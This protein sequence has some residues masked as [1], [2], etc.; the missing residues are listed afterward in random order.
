MIVES[1]FF[2]PIKSLPGIS[3]NEWWTEPKG[4]R[5]DRRMMLIDSTNKFV[6][7]RGVPEL[8]HCS[9]ELSEN[10]FLRVTHQSIGGDGIFLNLENP[11]IIDEIEVVI[12]NDTVKAGL[13][14]THLSNW[15]SEV[16]NKDLRLVFMEASQQR[17]IDLRYANEGEMVSFADGY[18]YLI[19]Q[20]SSLDYFN[21]KLDT[22]VEMIRFRPNIVLKGG[23]SFEEDHW[24]QLR[25]GEVEFKLVKPCGRC[26]VINID[27]NLLDLNPKVMETLKSFR[28]PTF[29]MNACLTGNE[30]TIRV[31]EEVVVLDQR[32]D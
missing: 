10:N 30:G 19:V 16:F 20:S 5:F 24:T 25:I 6:S 3:V 29:G 28:P 21:E 15:F 26:K 23:S 13:M 22:P 7:L 2:Y 11:K 32:I 27:P 31:G 18:P 8:Y 9:L 17:Q 14:E 4:F 12:W 1:I